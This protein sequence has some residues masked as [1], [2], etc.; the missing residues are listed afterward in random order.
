MVLFTCGDMLGDTSIEEHIEC[1]GEHLAQ[2][3]EKC[4][5]RYHV[6][7]W[8]DKE[9][10]VI[11]LIKKLEEMV[12]RNSLFCLNTTERQ[13]NLS[14]DM[15]E[16][17]EEEKRK[18]FDFLD[19]EWQRMDKAVEKKIKSICSKPVV[20]LKGSKDAFI[21]C[22]FLFCCS[23]LGMDKKK[24]HSYCFPKPTLQYFYLID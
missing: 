2:L 1:E 9:D 4:G 6:L 24:I 20:S 11:E 16:E 23:S 13:R 5:N 22:E 19:L 8:N 3:V 15:S 7:S 17:L 21:D 12:A 10:K 18:L 14:E